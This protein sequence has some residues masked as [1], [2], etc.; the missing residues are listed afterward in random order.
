M[1]NVMSDLFYTYLNL[2]RISLLMTLVLMWLALSYVDRIHFR[3]R[4]RRFGLWCSDILSHL[5]VKRTIYDKFRIYCIRPLCVV[6]DTFAG[7]LEG[8]ENLEAIILVADN[9]QKILSGLENIDDTQMLVQNTRSHDRDYVKI[10]T[11]ENI[12]K[13]KSNSEDRRNGVDNADTNKVFLD[14]I[15]KKIDQ[16]DDKHN[17]ENV[18]VID[19]NGNDEGNDRLANALRSSLDEN[20]QLSDD[21]FNDISDD[22][23]S[24]DLCTGKVTQTN[25]PVIV[26]EIKSTEMVK[27]VKVV[28]SMMNNRDPYVR[29]TS[30]TKTIPREDMERMN[31]KNDVDDNY[32]DETT[33]VTRPARNPSRDDEGSGEH[34]SNSKVGEKS[35]GSRTERKRSGL[36]TTKS[37][38]RGSKDSDESSNDSHKSNDSDSSKQRARRRRKMPIRL[39]RRRYQNI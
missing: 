30:Y 1:S 15:V 2:Y 29:N 11:K 7:F 39:A 17:N 23:Q 27:V 21:P 20:C 14:K 6:C 5:M 13:R 28:D 12:E 35:K 19:N 8:I 32:E 16:M 22:E 4:A 25:E 24:D 9:N 3:E 38:S 26:P 34:D 37:K 33:P 31:E 18:N 10:T 36:R